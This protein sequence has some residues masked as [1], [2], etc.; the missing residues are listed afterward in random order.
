[1]NVCVSRESRGQ[2]NEVVHVLGDSDVS[3]KTENDLV[4]QAKSGP[5]VRFRQ[6]RLV[7]SRPVMENLQT[8]IL[9]WKRLSKVNE[10]G[11]RLHCDQ[12]R[13]IVLIGFECPEEPVKQ[14]SPE[15]S[16]VHGPLGEYIAQDQVG[17]T[18]PKI[19]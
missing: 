5:E 6:I 8:V 11:W 14:S 13:N 3:P 16:R 12:I 15:D 7:Q 9:P 2:A 18:T 17:G 4:L 19:L 1:M 10:V